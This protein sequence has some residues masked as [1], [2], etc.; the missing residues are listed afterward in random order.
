M[1]NIY[2]EKGRGHLINI[3]EIE[4]NEYAIQVL[5]FGKYII[6]S[7]ES[8][9]HF[10]TWDKRFVPVC[11]ARPWEF[12]FSNSG[13]K[14]KSRDDKAQLAGDATKMRGGEYC[15][16]STS[17]Y[18]KALLTGEFKLWKEDKISSTSEVLDLLKKFSKITGASTNDDCVDYLL[19]M[20]EK[21][22][23]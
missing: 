5:I 19:A 4:E 18:E 6:M 20:A 23:K 3:S 16:I 2:K 14:R 15:P 22:C 1:R 11:N 9:F 13:E 17:G 12:I 10:Q 21:H 8:K 7:A